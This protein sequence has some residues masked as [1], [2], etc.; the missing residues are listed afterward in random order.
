MFSLTKRK[1]AAALHKSDQRFFFT[2]QVKINL[3]I[4]WLL[5][6]PPKL[7]VEPDDVFVVEN[8]EVELYWPVSAFPTA[9]ISWFRNGD[10]LDMSYGEENMFQ[11]YII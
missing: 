2:L 4:K 1:S 5:A 3:Q 6:V 9:E 8:D 10:P 7:L 11:L